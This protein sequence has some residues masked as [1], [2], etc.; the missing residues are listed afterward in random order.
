MW[1][2]WINKSQVLNDARSHRGHSG[3][4]TK[5]IGNEEKGH[6]QQEKQ[7]SPHPALF[8][9]TSAEIIQEVLMF[10]SVCGLLSNCDS[11]CIIKGIL[12]GIRY[13]SATTGVLSD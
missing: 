10:C 9:F 2:P 12:K 6:E 3:I 4:Q 13:L 5:V 8:S 11:K 1:V 7:Q